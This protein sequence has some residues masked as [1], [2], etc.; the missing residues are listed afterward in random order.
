MDYNELAAYHSLLPLI[1]TMETIVILFSYFGI[2]WA[3]RQQSDEGISRLHKSFIGIFLFEFWYWITRPALN[4]FKL[5]K[6]TPNGITG[7]S[8]FLSFITGAL[9]SFGFI[10]LGGWI[11]VVSAS[12]DMLDGALARE[13]G[14]VSKVGAFFDSCSD[15]YSDAFVF[16]GIAMFFLSKSFSSATGTFTISISDYIG[17]FVIMTILL[18]SAAMS[19]IKARGDVAGASTKR[20]LMQRPERVMMLSIFSVLDPFMKIILVKYGQNPDLV[21]IGMLII[22]SVLINISAI[23]R[24]THLFSII[25]GMES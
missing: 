13:T 4:F 7:I 16:I 25:K 17:V 14:Q 3:K 24:M 2:T 12:L 5:I 18:G 19:Y 11:L 15:R 9:Y 6:I 23:V 1:I 22:M 20:G 21:L 8:I 10:A